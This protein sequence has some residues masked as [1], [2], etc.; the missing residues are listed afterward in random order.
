MS[1]TLHHVGILVADIARAADEYVKKFG[2]RE[3]SEIVHDPVQTA[4]VQVL[5]LN[6][7]IP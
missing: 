2:Y 6:G 7:S 4:H 5:T 3:C 1:L